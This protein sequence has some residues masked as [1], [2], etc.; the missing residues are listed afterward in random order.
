MAK[1]PAFS[2]HLPSGLVLTSFLLHGCIMTIDEPPQGAG[3][4]T[5]GALSSST[6][7]STSGATGVGP[8][9]TTPT[10]TG[11]DSTF[12]P[13]GTNSSESAPTSS[14]KSGSSS[15]PSSAPGG[16]TSSTA[17]TSSDETS[18]QAP[19]D[20]L[21]TLDKNIDR[22]VQNYLK[23][24]ELLRM[25]GDIL[26][27]NQ[28]KVASDRSYL[29]KSGQRFAYGSITKSMTAVA[30]LQL[31]QAGKLKRSD[32]LRKHIPEL[33]R[34]FRG[35]TIE[36][37]LT[38]QS[39]LGNYLDDEEVFNFASKEQSRKQ[40]IDRI[41]KVPPTFTPGT[42]TNYSNSGY[43]LLGVIIERASEQSL[44]GYFESYIFGP[45]KM[46]DTS[47]WDD[48][49]SVGQFPDQG[50]LKPSPRSHPSVTFSAGAACGTKQDLIAFG[51]ALLD[52]TL[53]P[54][55]L[56][57]DMFK[58]HSQIGNTPY[59]YGVFS[60]ELADGRRII[61]HS[62]RTFGH[63]ASWYM[64]NEG[65]WNSVVL[66]NVSAVETDRIAWDSLEMAIT[67]KYVEPPA[68]QETLPFDP[69]VAKLMA[70]TYDLDPAQIP[71]LEK[72]LGSKVIEQIRQ[73]RWRGDMQYL[74]KPI[75]QGEFEV[76]QTAKDEFASQDAQIT[77]K[78]Q[79]E[80]ESKVTGL[81]LLQG[82]L[83]LRYLKKP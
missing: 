62:G 59:G 44:S 41:A 68:A 17:T 50:E 31:E 24:D 70:G 18:S 6:A 74:V 64:T 63:N 47:L 28:D 2:R 80:G 5:T 21:I 66:S 78:I 54:K 38:H 33:P 36:Q 42:K 72:T 55:K 16:A 7:V 27:T 45:A 77:L 79:R 29:E 73:L 9:G 52:G 30:I 57:E 32:S 20:P 13:T 40:M 53:L 51:R 25:R 11:Q 1:R 8:S 67:G 71:E 35:I 81:T 3:A 76:F 15:S 14:T 10:S 58:P 65:K 60:V 75:G 43:F 19:E 34:T 56:V 22:Y 12:V 82:P 26:V 46:T 23:G 37:L 4:G 69:A 83:A 48:N 39:G 49:I 61:G